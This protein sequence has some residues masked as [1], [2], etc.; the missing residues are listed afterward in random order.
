MKTLHHWASLE[1]LLGLDEDS[2]RKF[3]K[4]G[5]KLKSSGSSGLNTNKLELSGF[6]TSLAELELG[7]GLKRG[8]VPSLADRVPSR[9][10]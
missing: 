6:V 8:F 10:A 3:K 9:Y 5:E 1:T 4:P 2:M 7:L